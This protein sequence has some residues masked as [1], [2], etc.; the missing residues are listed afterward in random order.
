MKTDYIKI[1]ICAI[2][3]LLIISI[4]ANTQNTVAR[5]G[6]FLENYNQGHLINPALAPSRGYINIPVAGSFTSSI[7]SNMAL[8]DFVYK[9]DNEDGKLD[10]FMSSNVPADKF[11]NKL[12]NKNTF[13]TEVR[14]SIISFGF[15][16]KSSFITFDISSKNMIYANI[17][18]EFFRFAKLGMAEKTGSEY[19]I[20]DMYVEGNSVIEFAGGYS[21]EIKQIKNLRVGGKIKV[22]AGIAHAKGNIQNMKISLLTDKYKIESRGQVDIY[23]KK[24]SF[25]ND[26]DGNVDWDTGDFSFGI[27]GKGLGLDLGASYSPIKDLDLSLSVSDIGFIKWDKKNKFTAKSNGEVTF[28]GFDE[29]GSQKDKGEYEEVDDQLDDLKDD[30]EAMTDMKQ[31]GEKDDYTQH[32]NSIINFGAEYSFLNRK[33]GIGTLL[34]TRIG[35]GE[36]SSFTELMGALNFRPYKIIQFATTYSFIHGT[37]NA[38]GFD[39]NFTP[40]IVNINIACDY[41]VT[42]VTPE[43]I[44]I[45]KAVANFQF[46]IS[47]PLAYRKK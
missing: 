44:P 13:D 34:T 33:I 26:K 20:N 47:V 4:P 1:H 37:G 42:K 46:G 18:K 29:I 6:Y 12:D 25:D 39:I 45:N 31:N 41:L 10:L 40:W 16:K 27:V 5:S 9:T 8:K 38:F 43:M 14:I 35:N 36:R 28:T 21:Q 30:F 24:V 19:N 3:I 23:G 17:P 15:W 2:I 7:E 11:L 22:L 32:L